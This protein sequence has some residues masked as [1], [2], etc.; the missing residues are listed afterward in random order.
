MSLRIAVAAPA[1]HV[2]DDAPGHG[3]FGKRERVA[4]VNGALRSRAAPGGGLL[5]EARLPV[6]AA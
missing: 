5:V 1:V 4:A 2:R 6:G 3:P